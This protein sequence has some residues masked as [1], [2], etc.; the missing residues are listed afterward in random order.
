M[1]LAFM[2]CA[3]LALKSLRFEQGDVS[4]LVSTCPGNLVISAHLF[5]NSCR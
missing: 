1:L 3:H 2:D 5:V 4:H